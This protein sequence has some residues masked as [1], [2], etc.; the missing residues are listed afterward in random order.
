FSLLG[1]G[2]YS[3]TLEQTGF[4]KAEQQ[5]TVN[6]GQVNSA[7]FAL[8]IGQTSQT[9]E[10]TGTAPV[11]NVDTANVSTSFDHRHLANVPNPGADLT[12]VAQTAPGVTMN[13]SGGYG[14]FTANGLPGTANLF[15]INGENDMDPFFN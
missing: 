6:V 9:V 13:T 12:N 5:V 11:I 8:Q 4:R 15:T 7:N 1:P 10:V 3:V 14:N 2:L